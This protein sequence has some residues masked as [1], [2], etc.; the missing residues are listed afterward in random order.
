MPL[1]MW[2]AIIGVA[3]W[4]TYRPGCSALKLKLLVSPGATWV[5]A[6]PPPGPVTAW[7]STEWMLTLLSSFLRLMVTSSPWRTRSI[8][9]GTVLLKVQ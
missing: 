5:T 4:Y 7:K 8:G 6:A 1:E 9:P 3:Q 2:W